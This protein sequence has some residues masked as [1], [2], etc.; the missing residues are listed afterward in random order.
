MLVQ[1]GTSPGPAATA[2]SA[3]SLARSQEHSRPCEPVVETYV[4]WQD[5]TEMLTLPPGSVF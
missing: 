5:N 1:P 4:P 2:L 3:T